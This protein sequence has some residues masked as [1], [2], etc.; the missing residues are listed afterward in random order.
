MIDT[1]TGH[2]PAGRGRPPRGFTLV[3]LLVVIAIIS[4]LMALLLPALNKVRAQAKLTACQSNLRQIGLGLRMFANDNRD[5]YPNAVATGNYAYRMRPGL[6]TPN[7]PS[8]L[9]ETYGLAAV[10]HGI[11]PGEDLS[12]GLPSPARYLP[13]D[14]DVWICPAQTPQ[15]IAQGNTYAFSI[16]GGLDEWTSIHRARKPDGLVVWDNYTLRPG[17]SGFR[18][19]F[20]GYSI[21]SA[22]R[23]Y[24][25]QRATQGR[26]AVSELHLGGEVAIRII[27]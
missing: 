2:T 20:S 23:S 1:F 18:G 6:R 8:A 15:M 9:P 24:P 22:Q 17:L 16:A 11:S 14:S 19:P 21:P 10:L 4:V 5:R 7:E 27:K 26:G 3:E 25:H 13:A 12:H